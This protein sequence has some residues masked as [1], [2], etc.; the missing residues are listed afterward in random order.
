MARDVL[1][2]LNASVIERT[3]FWGY[4]MGGFRLSLGTNCAQPRPCDHQASFD[5]PPEIEIP[6]KLVPNK[7]FFYSK[8]FCDW[9][10][11]YFRLGSCIRINS[12]FNGVAKRRPNRGSIAGNN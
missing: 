12:D 10:C 3:P 6:L 9:L 11:R 2:V 1:A 5:A 8:E 4:L 7:E